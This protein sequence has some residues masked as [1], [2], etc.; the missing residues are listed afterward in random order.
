TYFENLPILASTDK[1]AT[2]D[3]LTE[4]VRSLADGNKPVFNSLSKIIL[5]ISPNELGDL[6]TPLYQARQVFK[7]R[8]S[9]EEIDTLL[10][11]VRLRHTAVAE[12]NNL[13]AILGITKEPTGGELRTLGAYL[14]FLLK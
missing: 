3:D 9:Q 8:A 12:A 6:D 4:R 14:T 5:G 2:T 7:G 11:E 1:R 13:M 10:D